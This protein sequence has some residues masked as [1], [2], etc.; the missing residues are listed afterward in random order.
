M[1]LLLLSGLL[2]WSLPPIRAQSPF[3]GTWKIDDSESEAPT[4]GDEYLL[5]NARYRCTTCDPPLDVKANAQ[6]QKIT[7]DPCYD[8]VNL[9]VVDDRTTIETDKRK[10]KAV[11]TRKMTV[12][13]DGNAAT[14][15]WMESCN[16]K[17]DAV[18]GELI[19]SR[20]T[21]GPP[22]SHAVSGSWQIVKR[23]NVSENALVITLKLNGDT[24]SFADPTGQSFSAKLDGTEAPFKGDL[25]H[26]MASVKRLDENSI[27]VTNKIDGKVV[28]VWRFTPSADGNTMT[29]AREIR[30][31]GSTQQIVAHKQ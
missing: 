6:D 19:L 31:K 20:I 14:I 2:I 12:A 16:A 13:T 11:R 24:F 8:S 30:A 23:L 17:G 26:T 5:Q 21:Q 9:K 27:E 18:S 1:K 10:G 4:K 7:G 29:I 28:E 25:S 22:G 15:D 3:D